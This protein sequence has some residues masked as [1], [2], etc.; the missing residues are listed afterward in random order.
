MRR[1]KSIESCVRARKQTSNSADPH[2]ERAQK[3]GYGNQRKDI[4][5]QIGHLFI[6]KTLYV[7]YMFYFSNA[8]NRPSRPD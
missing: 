3:Q 7:L 4:L 6:Q 8:V 5:K 1:S 2:C